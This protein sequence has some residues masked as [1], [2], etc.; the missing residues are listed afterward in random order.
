MDT[1]Y[2]VEV[3]VAV[4]LC[5]S[6]VGV[7]VVRDIVR[8]TKLR[9]TS[10]LDEISS[11]YSVDDD[12]DFH[13]GTTIETGTVVEKQWRG[14]KQKWLYFIQRGEFTHQLYEEKIVGEHRG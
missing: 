4:V 7:V 9:T 6:L 5:I 13:Y 8:H 14:D 10:V 3:M 11:M 2:V 1:H 12:V